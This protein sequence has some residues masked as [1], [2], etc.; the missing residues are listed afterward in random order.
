MF[1]VSLLTAV[2]CFSSL[3]LLLQYNGIVSRIVSVDGQ[4]VS[5]LFESSFEL[6]QE[7]SCCF[8]QFVGTGNCYSSMWNE[9]LSFTHWNTDAKSHQFLSALIC[10]VLKM[11]CQIVKQPN[12]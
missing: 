12:A 3:V 1:N 9:S 4:D 5:S 7:M 11:F 6:E 10:C 2:N 8:V